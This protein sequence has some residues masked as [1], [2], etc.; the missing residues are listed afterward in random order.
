MFVG[1]STV[2]SSSRSGTEW[3]NPQALTSFLNQNTFLSRHIL[4][5]NSMP[6]S[7][8]PDSLSFLSTTSLKKFQAFDLKTNFPH[9]NF[10]F[11]SPRLKKYLNIHVVFNFSWLLLSLKI[12]SIIVCVCEWML[13]M[14][15]FNE[16]SGSEDGGRAR[17]KE[18]K[19]H[20]KFIFLPPK[21]KQKLGSD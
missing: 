14:Y 15:A 1:C 3:I 8:F 2:M 19:L 18:I 17:G 10:S 6:I 7:A 5:D 9:E 21:E 16:F 11:H 20:W 12:Q 4:Q 13:S